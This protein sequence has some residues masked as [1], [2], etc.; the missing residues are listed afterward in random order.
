MGIDDLDVVGEANDETGDAAKVG[1]GGVEKPMIIVVDVD[2][3]FGQG[4]FL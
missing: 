4:V 2:V 1:D 3:L